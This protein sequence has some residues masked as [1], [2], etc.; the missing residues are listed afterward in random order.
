ML[1]H[2]DFAL[3]TEA[4][5]VM[6]AGHDAEKSGLSHNGIPGETGF[7]MTVRSPEDTPL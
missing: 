3:V 7:G 1:C 2:V 6:V 4:A 5:A